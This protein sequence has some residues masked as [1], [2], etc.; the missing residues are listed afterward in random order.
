MPVNYKATA[1]L[2]GGTGVIMGAFGAHA[3]K[4]L[5]TERGTL[6][7]WHTAVNYQLFHAL[8]LL[9]LS[10]PDAISD[11]DEPTA[12]LWFWGTLLFSGSIYG[13]SVGG[14]KILGPVTPIG[15]LLMITGWATLAMRS[16]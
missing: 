2:M 1:A 16:Y 14:P 8:A 4:A 3:L 9:A 12:R 7:S 13:L 11:E 15:G 10:R 6:Q 5:L